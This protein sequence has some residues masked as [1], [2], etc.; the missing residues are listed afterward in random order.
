MRN[1]A[2]RLGRQTGDR[3]GLDLE[4]LAPPDVDHRN[5]SVSELPV[6]R[7]VCSEFEHFLE[8]KFCHRTFSVLPSEN[9]NCGIG[10]SRETRS[11]VSALSVATDRVPIRGAQSSRG[12]R[13]RSRPGRGIRRCATA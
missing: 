6:F 5:A 7:V 2:D 11:R 1:I 10:P 4:N 3:L 13:I 12:D 8:V 9:V